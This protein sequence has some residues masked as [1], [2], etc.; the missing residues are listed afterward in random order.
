MWKARE[1]ELAANSGSASMRKHSPLVRYA[2]II[3]F[4]TA[5]H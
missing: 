1:T 5:I 4:Y 3:A 2:F